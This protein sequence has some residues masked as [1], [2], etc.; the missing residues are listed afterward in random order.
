MPRLAEEGL[1]GSPRPR[2]ERQL[3]DM[4]LDQTDSDDKETSDGW[5]SDLD[6]MLIFAALFSA[7]LTAFVIESYQSL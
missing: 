2:A 1:D 7:V 3:W 4:Y 5:D 6:S